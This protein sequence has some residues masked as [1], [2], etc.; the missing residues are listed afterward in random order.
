MCAKKIQTCTSA[1]GALDEMLRS[2]RYRSDCKKEMG[3]KL[4]ICTSGLASR[5]SRR[6]WQ[7]T[8]E[9]GWVPTL[10]TQGIQKCRGG[11]R[12][13]ACDANGSPSLTFQLAQIDIGLEKVPI[14]IMLCMDGTFIK[15]G[16]P[17]RPIYCKFCNMLHKML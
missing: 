14:S 13:L 15:R 11:G 10:C 1:I 3:I 2:R 5:S 16:I 7:I 8:R 6:Y 17:I 4:F 12:I 9:I